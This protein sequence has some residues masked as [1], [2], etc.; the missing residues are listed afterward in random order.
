MLHFWH[1]SFLISASILSSPS[2]GTFE[3]S[4]SF[5]TFIFG[6]LIHGIAFVL[7]YI[8]YLAIRTLSLNPSSPSL[9]APSQNPIQHLIRS[10]AQSHPKFRTLNLPFC[11]STNP[12][13]IQPTRKLPLAQQHPSIH[14]PHQSL[15]PRRRSLKYL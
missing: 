12:F 10:M 5:L 11:V 13:L 1:F 7:L 3:G 2:Y 15:N 9:L 4:S 6:Y 8:M 14:F